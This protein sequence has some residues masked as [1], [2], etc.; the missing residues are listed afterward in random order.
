MRLFIYGSC[1]S[2]DALEFQQDGPE[3]VKYVA[4]TSLAVQQS[5]PKVL[6]S[7][8]ERIPSPFQREMMMIDMQKSLFQLLESEQYDVLLLDFIDERFGIAQFE[9]DARFTLSADLPTL[10]A[11]IWQLTNNE[12][13]YK[14]LHRQGVS[15]INKHYSASQFVAQVRQ[16]FDE[17]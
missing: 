14:E 3:L 17:I 8:L 2:R 12:A 6:T 13:A 16:L 4:R 11:R 15:Y 9:D 5:A 10:V 1:V 7:L